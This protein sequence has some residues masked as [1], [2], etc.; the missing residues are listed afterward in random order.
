MAAFEVPILPRDIYSL[1][2]VV[3]H[4]LTF[5]FC[6]LRAAKIYLATPPVL[7]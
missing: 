6:F 7:I 3:I 4:Y 5:V 1:L 2:F